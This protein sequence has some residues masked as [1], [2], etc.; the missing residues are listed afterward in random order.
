MTRRYFAKVALQRVDSPEDQ[1]LFYQG[2]GMYELTRGEFDA[3]MLFDQMSQQDRLQAIVRG[4]RAS[5]NDLAV[6]AE[7]V[8]RIRQLDMKYHDPLNGI[9]PQ[10]YLVGLLAILDLKAGG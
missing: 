1:A 6:N 7:Q 4:V 9:T 10:E 3:V 8:A 2:R 5:E